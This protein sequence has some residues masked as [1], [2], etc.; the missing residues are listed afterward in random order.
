LEYFFLPPIY[1]LQLGA[2]DIP[3][4]GVYLLTPIGISTLEAKRR[5]AEEA[6]RKSEQRMLIARSIQARW[7][8]LPPPNVAGF[9]IAG[10]SHPAEETGGDFYDFIPMRDGRIGI[11]IGDVS[12]HGFGAALFMAETRAYLRALTS[13]HDNVGDI[14]T[15]TNAMVTA[16]TK[17]DYF[18]TL[19][20]ACIHPTYRSLVY[21]AAGHEAYLLQPRAAA[22]D[23]Q[24]QVFLSA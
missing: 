1:A 3:L 12:G 21:A 8:P 23:S 16:D 5:R 17:D 24:A 19:F 13:T 10:A 20:I 15:L 9:D 11:V 22:P 2:E 14:L 7:C 6:L 18:V 4:A